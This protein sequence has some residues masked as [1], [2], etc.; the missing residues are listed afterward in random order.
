MAQ[1][2]SHVVAGIENIGLIN[3]ILHRF[4]AEYQLIFSLFAAVLQD[5]I[6]CNADPP[7][8]KIGTFLELIE[9]FPH[10]KS[11][12]LHDIITYTVIGY[13]GIYEIVDSP[14]I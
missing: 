12:F 9:M 1:S 14:L 7:C 6:S 11:G 8:G 4:E 2:F 3:D 13:H 10:K 5:H